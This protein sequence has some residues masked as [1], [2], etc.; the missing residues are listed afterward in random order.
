LV[1]SKDDSV[2]TSLPLMMR[3]TVSVLGNVILTDIFA[4]Q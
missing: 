3:G 1:T 2:T 4:C